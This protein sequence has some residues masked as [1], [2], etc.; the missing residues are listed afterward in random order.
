MKQIEDAANALMHK[1]SLEDIADESRYVKKKIKASE[2]KHK[3]T[4]YLDDTTYAY[5]KSI[6]AKEV[7]KS[8]SPNKSK[9]ICE[10]IKLYHYKMVQEENAAKEEIKNKKTVSALQKSSTEPQI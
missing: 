10:S 4:I 1:L 6:C 7:K 9:I 8:G 2:T 3:V 5:Y